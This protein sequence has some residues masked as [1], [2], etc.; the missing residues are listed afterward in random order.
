MAVIITDTPA[1]KE[2][3]EELSTL[4]AAIS[5]KSAQI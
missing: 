5:V 4:K 2:V 1:S 3:I